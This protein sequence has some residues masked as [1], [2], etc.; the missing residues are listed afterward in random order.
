MD[1]RGEELAYAPQWENSKEFVDIFSL[2]LWSHKLSGYKDFRLSLAL[3]KGNSMAEL[4][5]EEMI[6]NAVRKLC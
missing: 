2:S 6:L 4:G 5:I 3:Q 1:V